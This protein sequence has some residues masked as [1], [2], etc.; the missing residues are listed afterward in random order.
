MDVEVNNTDAEDQEDPGTAAGS[1]GH[2]TGRGEVKVGR[3]KMSS[4]LAYM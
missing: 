1:R 4:Y 3:D 2:E